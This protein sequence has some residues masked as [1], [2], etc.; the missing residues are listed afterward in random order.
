MRVQLEPPT[1]SVLAYEYDKKQCSHLFQRT[2]SVQTLANSSALL[3][4]YHEMQ[5]PRT[6]QAR[7]AELAK[8]A[9]LLIRRIPTD[10]NGLRLDVFASQSS[11]LIDVAQS[12]D[13]K[14]SGQDPLSETLFSRAIILSEWPTSGQSYMCKR[15]PVFMKSECS[16]FQACCDGHQIWVTNLPIK[17]AL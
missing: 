14:T 10:A 4:L 12:H 7:I 9:D 8:A 13:T 6:T 15:L 3:E 16:N 5:N 1:E 11:L 2:P 17:N